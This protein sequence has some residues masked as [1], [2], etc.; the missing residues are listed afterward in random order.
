MRELLIWIMLLS[1]VTNARSQTIRWNRSTDKAWILSTEGNVWLTDWRSESGLEGLGAKMR[2]NIDPSLIYNVKLNLEMPFVTLELNRS[3]STMGKGSFDDDIQDMA[4]YLN[5]SGFIYKRLFESQA[6]LV[7]V[8]YTTFK[9]DLLLVNGSVFGMEPNDLLHLDSRWLKYDA[10][11]MV[12]DY[13]RLS[14]GIGYRH[15]KYEKPQAFTYFYGTA[16]NDGDLST[17]VADELISATIER[18]TLTGNYLILHYLVKRS[19]EFNDYFGDFSFG[20]GE[21]D[22]QGESNY[23]EGKIGV[24]VDASVNYGWNFKLRDKMA[25]QLNLGY[26]FMYN[27]ITVANDLG[28]EPDGH[29]YLGTYSSELWHGPVL[30]GGLA[31]RLR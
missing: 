17:V 30:S 19:M 12:N 29:R 14:V 25:F 8:M 20:M 2:Y 9:G 4:R 6:L 15:I 21:A 31:F 26:K 11:F 24:F 10:I 28:Q 5:Y 23:L 16:Q 7:D 18:S 1:V 3:S 13:G 27:K 22:V